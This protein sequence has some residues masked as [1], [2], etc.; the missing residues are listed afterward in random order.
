MTTNSSL[1]GGIFYLVIG[2]HAV[3]VIGAL[4]ALGLATRK[5]ARG[6][7]SPESHGG[8]S[9][10]RFFWYFVVGIWPVLYIMVYVW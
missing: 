5:V 1:Y 2:A 7:Y 4:V 8:L 10:V 3:H 9:A 6:G